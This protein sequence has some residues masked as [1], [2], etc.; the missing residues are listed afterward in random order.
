[1][2]HPAYILVTGVCALALL[3]LLV[4][5]HL[6]AKRT[7]LSL[8]SGWA[9]ILM[10]LLCLATTVRIIPGGPFISAHADI[11]PAISCI[12]VL[13]SCVRV[14]QISSVGRRIGLL[15]AGLGSVGVILLVV[16]D[17]VTFWQNRFARGGMLGW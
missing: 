14:V 12:V 10:S 5:F 3:G 2:E 9:V 7:G 15:F 4:R 13:V 6:Q 11:L 8:W 16:T 17:I 1:M